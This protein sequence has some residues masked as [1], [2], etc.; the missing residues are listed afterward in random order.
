LDDLSVSEIEQLLELKPG[1]AH[2]I[3][4]GLFVDWVIVSS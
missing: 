2:L 3:L 4:R 1:D